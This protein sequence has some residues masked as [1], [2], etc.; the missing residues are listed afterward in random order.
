MQRAVCRQ[1]TSTSPHLDGQRKGGCLPMENG[2]GDSL[3]VSWLNSSSIGTPV[4]AD[5]FST[6]SNASLPAA[7]YTSLTLGIACGEE[8]PAHR[9][10]DERL[11]GGGGSSLG[12]SKG[13]RGCTNIIHVCDTEDI[14]RPWPGTNIMHV[15]VVQSRVQSNKEL[16]GQSTQ[17]TTRQSSQGIWQPIHDTQHVYVPLGC[18]TETYKKQT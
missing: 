14:S 3:W 15:C 13:S 11:L 17:P 12:G 7:L 16:S 18:N 9:A 8:A 4:K 2:T 10:E 6:A 1:C 5:S